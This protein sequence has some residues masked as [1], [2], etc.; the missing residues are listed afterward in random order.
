MYARLCFCC[1]SLVLLW[2]YM[3]RSALE[4]STEGKESGIMWTEHTEWE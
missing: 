3:G 2:V 4:I 1:S